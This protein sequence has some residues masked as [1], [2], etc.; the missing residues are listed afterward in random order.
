MKK[1]GPNVEMDV[2]SFMT[3]AP[4]ALTASINH[5][6]SPVLL[7]S[8][9]EMDTWING[10]PDEARTLLH[11]TP[12]EAMTIVQDGFEKRDLMGG[13]V[14]AQQVTGRLL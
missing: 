5:E 13:A 6:R 3:T 2:Y 14:N 9:D 1:D 12:A 8:T 4:N 11:P 10:S 7:R